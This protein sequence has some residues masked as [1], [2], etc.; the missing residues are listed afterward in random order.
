MRSLRAA[1]RLL[2]MLL[3]LPPT[4]EAVKPLRCLDALP[5]ACLFDI[6][7]AKIAVRAHCSTIQQT[8]GGADDNVNRHDG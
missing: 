7:P 6:V 5:D 8:G 1:W 2:R 4:E 3:R